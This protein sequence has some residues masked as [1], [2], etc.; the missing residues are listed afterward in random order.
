[1]Q[2]KLKFNPVIAPTGA[3]FCRGCKLGARTN[4]TL[5]VGAFNDNRIR[6][7]T[8]NAARNDVAATKIIYTHPS[9]VLALEAAPDG[10]VYFSDRNGI[11]RLKR[12]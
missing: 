12:T 11:Y 10:R 3:A 6:R 5:L 1:M 4:G 8:L 7:L 2:P 9:F